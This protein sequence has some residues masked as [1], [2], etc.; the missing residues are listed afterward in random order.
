MFSLNSLIYNDVKF[1][2]TLNDDKF[3]LPPNLAW[4]WMLEFN[5][6]WFVF[7]VA[8]LFSFLAL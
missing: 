2:I 8:G 1:I 6:V 4:P 5:I 3:E 7:G